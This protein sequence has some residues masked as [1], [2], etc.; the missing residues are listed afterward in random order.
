M[1]DYIKFME[2]FYH[3]MYIPIY[4]YDNSKELMY[5]YPKQDTCTYPLPSYLST[6]S[7]SNEPVAYMETKFHTYYGLIQIKNC[8]HSFIIGPVNPFPYTR[9]NLSTMHKDFQINPSDIEIF[10]DFFHNIPH[11]NLDTFVNI[12]IFINFI[13]NRTQLTKS[14]VIHISNQDLYQSINKKYYEN[15]YISMETLFNT[16]IEI[17]RELF[18]IIESGNTEQLKYFFDHT[19]FHNY[20]A[21]TTSND[22]LRQTKNNFISGISL[23][24]RAAMKGGLT[25]NTGYNLFNV[26]IHQVEK[27]SE[28]KAIDA[29]LVQAA[30]DYTQRTSLSKIPAVANVTLNE[31][32]NFVNENIYKNITVADIAE[33]LHFNRSY[34]SRKFKKEYGEELAKFIQKSKLE[35]SKRLLEYS[36]KS[37]SEISILLCYSSQSHFQNVFKK[38]FGMTPLWYRCSLVSSM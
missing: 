24:S 28:I 29:L 12:L 22:Y 13:V 14:D 23:I 37:I 17:E 35:E 32:I 1:D 31:I 8:E 11:H 15:P 26:Y 25:S 27:L 10:S 33:Y 20:N 30:F 21:G 18:G 19:N 38:Y 16:N 7:I 34:L 3:S 2:Y 5:C 6:L 4:L 36:N 9:D